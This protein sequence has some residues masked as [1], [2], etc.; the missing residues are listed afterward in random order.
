MAVAC[1]VVAKH[2][3]GGEHRLVLYGGAVQ[4][5]K[6][7]LEVPGGHSYGGLAQLS[8]Q[9]WGSI[10]PDARL[11]ALSQEHGLAKVTP[12]QFDL[13]QV[14]DLAAVIPVHSCLTV[15]LYPDYLSLEG[16]KIGIKRNLEGCARQR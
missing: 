16:R 12:E 14:G 2:A 7:A 1:P 15:D 4:L 5:S 11:Y 6:E 10:L 9:G 13:F 8:P 3:E